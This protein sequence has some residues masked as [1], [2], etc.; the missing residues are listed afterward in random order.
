[1][2]LRMRMPAAPPSLSPRLRR[3]AIRVPVAVSPARPLV[4]GPWP[5]RHPCRRPHAPVSPRKSVRGGAACPAAPPR[6]VAS[7][8]R[9][10]LRRRSARRPGRR[11]PEACP[12][13]LR[14]PSN[15]Q[16]MPEPRSGPTSRARWSMLP[17]VSGRLAPMRRCSRPPARWLER[18]PGQRLPRS[19]SPQRP[20]PARHLRP[21]LPG[22]ERMP[23]RALAERLMGAVAWPSPR[24]TP[25]RRARRPRSVDPPP[26]VAP[27][28]RGRA[29]GGPCRAMRRRS[30]CPRSSARP[31]RPFRRRRRR[32]G[33]PAPAA[34]GQRRHAPP[35]RRTPRA[36]G[37][38][39]CVS[40]PRAAGQE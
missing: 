19:S 16:E 21:P 11:S 33:G 13:L 22:R 34:S 2:R 1:M 14:S 32:S 25:S 6:R 10:G 26:P 5:V 9:P 7:E 20:H 3:S 27:P 15:R 24:R 39:W 36:G 12:Q 38:R 4:P 17:P 29:C 35:S 18:Q 8:R 23:R 28:P 37:L 30:R 40:R 31:D